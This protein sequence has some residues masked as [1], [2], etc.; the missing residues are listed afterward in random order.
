MRFGLFYELQLPRPWE[1]GGEQQLF[2]QSLDEV[3]LADRLGF[4]NM[5]AVEHHFLE[6]YSHC[7]APEIFLAACSQR[8]RN[9]RLGHGIM[10]MPSGFNH[11]ARSAERIATLDLVSNGRVEWGTGQASSLLELGGYGVALADKAEAWREA[12]EQATRMLAM[13]PYPGHE[14]RFFSMPCRNIVPKPVQRPHPPLWVACSN[15]ETIRLAARLG[16]GAL[17]FAFV[18]PG[19]AKTWVDEYYRVFKEEC[20]PLGQAVNP[21]FCMVSSFG[22]HQDAAIARERFREGFRFFQFAVGWHYGFG[23]HRPGRTSLWERFQTALPHMPADAP[24]EGG[25]SDPAGIRDHLRM[26]HE[27]GVDQVAFVQQAGRTKHEHI[28]EAIE[29]FAAEVMGEFRAGEAEREARKAAELAPY[30]EAAFQ[31]KQALQQLADDQVEPVMALGREVAEK[32]RAEGQPKRI[33]WRDALA[34][35]DEEARGR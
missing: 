5:W 3:E 34:M 19:E 22:V 6:E 7:S 11:P 24:S 18:H 8:T 16:I 20:V 28:R 25:I 17:T 14:G 21:N 4:D 32:P 27:A 13:E 2:Q 9:I 31:R 15:R 10:L 33:G 35:G 23:D 29:L 30:I 1:A 26:F 12:V